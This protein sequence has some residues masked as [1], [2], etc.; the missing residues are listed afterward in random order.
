MITFSKTE[1]DKFFHKNKHLRYGQ[2]FYHYFK[3]EKI[4]GEDKPFCD[5]L[6]VAEDNDAKSMIAS[7]IDHSQ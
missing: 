6:Y 3:L 5:K 7:R 1:V 4:T 2:E